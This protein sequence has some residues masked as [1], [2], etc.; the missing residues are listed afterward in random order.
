MIL[1]NFYFLVCSLTLVHVINS[2]N[3]NP[4][5]KIDTVDIE[6]LY[7]ALLQEQAK[8]SNKTIVKPQLTVKANFCSLN[9]PNNSEKKN[10]LYCSNF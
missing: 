7:K 1:S 3:I 2:I 5:R 8:N 9:C 4:Q 6:G 10:A